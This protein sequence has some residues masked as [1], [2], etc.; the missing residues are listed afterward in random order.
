MN[1]IC[2][3]LYEMTCENIPCKE[4]IQM[5]DIMV[6]ISHV[7]VS[8]IPWDAWPPV[9]RAKPQLYQQRWCLASCSLSKWVG[10][11]ADVVAGSCLHFS[12][13]SK[14]VSAVRWVSRLLLR[15][16]MGVGGWLGVNPCSADLVFFSSLPNNF[17]STWLVFDF[18]YA[19]STFMLLKL[20][21]CSWSP[22]KQV[23]E[24][25]KK[26]KPPMATTPLQKKK[27]G[28]QKN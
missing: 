25:R 13:L 22:E 11:G 2:K 16:G 12:L 21:S 6:Q 14:L 5:E 19:S 10:G 24:K 7:W 28:G 9:L 3:W 20:N 15:T 18:S 27:G 23:T 26:K 17:T 1:K 8:Q 4:V